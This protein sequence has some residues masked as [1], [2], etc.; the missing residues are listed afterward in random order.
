MELGEWQGSRQRHTR[1]SRNVIKQWGRGT[2]FS[3]F[4]FAVC[5]G[6]GR[7]ITPLYMMPQKA[8]VHLTS[9]NSHRDSFARQA[10][11]SASFSLSA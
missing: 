4:R 9:I 2:C 8:F 11:D 7:S 1:W 10:I 5:Q 3:L 6:V